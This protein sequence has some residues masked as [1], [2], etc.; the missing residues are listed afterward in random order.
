MHCFQ[1]LVAADYDP[2]QDPIW[3]LY[4]LSEDLV[5]VLEHDCVCVVVPAGDMRL[6]L[7]QVHHDSAGHPGE[8][9]TLY[10]LQQHYFWPNMA[11]DVSKYC[12]SCML[13]QAT[14]A[15]AWKQPGSS[16][17]HPISSMLVP[18]FAWSLDFLKLPETAEG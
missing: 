13:C 3:P 11:R 12:A 10:A 6:K 14:N 8:D 7:L 16:Q 17:P 2:A 4:S 15:A 18:G 9:R 5:V 1:R